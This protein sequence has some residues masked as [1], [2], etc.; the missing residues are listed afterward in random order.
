MKTFEMLMQI[1]TRE[2]RFEIRHGLRDDVKALKSIYRETREGTPSE[3][4]AAYI[5]AVG[6]NRAAVAIGTL[7]N[8]HSWD[9]RI[10]R[11]AAAWAAALPEA[12]DEKTAVEIGLYVDDVIHL[13]HFDQIVSAFMKFEPDPEKPD[14]DER[15]ETISKEEATEAQEKEAERPETISKD[16]RKEGRKTMKYEKINYCILGRFENGVK[17]GI[18]TRRTVS[19]YM[20]E[21]FENIG[22]RKEKGFWYVDHIQT[23]LAI[24]S[25]GSKTR[26]AA[27]KIYMEKYAAR[28]Q[29]I[30]MKIIEKMIE[31][32][33]K[34][35]NE[36]EVGAW[37]TVNY[38][39]T[40]NYRFDKVT[41]AARRA[42]L[43]IRNADNNTYI[44]G[45]NINIIGSP[46]ALKGIREMIAEY[47]RKDAERAA[48]EAAQIVPEAQEA[49]EER[50]EIISEEPTPEVAQAEQEEAKAEPEAVAQTV[51]S[52]PARVPVKPKDFAWDALIGRG[53]CIVF[54]TGL[55]RTRVIVQDS[56]RETVAPIIRESGFYWSV[57]MG[58]YN[59]KLTYK[60]Y[61]AAL[62]LA[63][64]LESATA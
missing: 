46:D 27:L 10:S 6:Y 59:K 53:W 40:R 16:E 2:E 31:N 50:K 62:A 4:V 57:N 8:R 34:A 22:F 24:V 18:L 37:E 26:E 28:V 3:T 36:E 44:D 47:D 55:Q 11:R 38:C 5:K 12:W 17:Y 32:Y 63:V 33:E 25:I 64:K 29:K 56:I 19:G 23:G 21:G 13:A 49:P 58:S 7:V 61:R 43:L 1:E 41:D 20:A 52:K 51:E 15:P 60:A 45:G 14:P 30:D 39:T 48:E 54:D 35:P 9:G 42:N